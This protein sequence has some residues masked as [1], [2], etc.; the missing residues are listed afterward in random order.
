MCLLKYECKRCGKSF[1]SGEIIPLL[2]RIKLS[3]GHGA[4]TV[5]KFKRD[6]DLAELSYVTKPADFKMEKRDVL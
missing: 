2:A 5:N 6:K 4:F 3:C 1:I